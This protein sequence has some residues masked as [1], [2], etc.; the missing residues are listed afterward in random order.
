MRLFEVQPSCAVFMAHRSY[1]Q[2]VE[3]E[4]R[5]DAAG[6]SALKADIRTGS[7]ALVLVDLLHRNRW[8]EPLMHYDNCDA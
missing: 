1:G 7:S 8:S 5:V 6:Y 4:R 2:R 3:N